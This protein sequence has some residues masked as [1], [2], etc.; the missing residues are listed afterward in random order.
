LGA[1]SPHPAARYARVHPPRKRGG[2]GADLSKSLTSAAVLDVDVGKE[3]A[4]RT[5][6]D[7]LVAEG[8]F[9]N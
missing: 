5:P 4:R 3:D 8:D 1:R 9:L 7:D 2:I 6:V